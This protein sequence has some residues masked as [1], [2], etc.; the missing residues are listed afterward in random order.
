MSFEKLWNECGDVRGESC[1]FAGGD[2]AQLAFEPLE[3]MRVCDMAREEVYVPG[4]D[5]VVSGRSI[6][7]VEGGRIPWVDE[8]GL[9]P[10]AGTLSRYP[11]PDCQVI[12]NGVDGRDIRF[13][14]TTWYMD[15]QF[16]VDYVAKKV[17]LTVLSGLGN[18]FRE[19]VNAR[20]EA[21]KTFRLSYIGDSIT[22][23]CNASKLCDV[24]PYQPCYAELV[25]EELERATGCEMVFKNHAIGGTGCR[26]AMKIKDAWMGDKA[27]LLVIAYGMNDFSG[28]TAEDYVAVTDDI[29]NNAVAAHPDT[30]VLLV[31]SMAGNSDWKNTPAEPAEAFATALRAYAAQRP[32][33][34]FADV[35]A[36]WREYVSRKGYYSMT[37]NGVNHPNDFG[38]RVYASCL[39]EEILGGYL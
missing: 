1:M 11:S 18:G 30:L 37:G 23:G 26:N 2:V 17:D 5:Y 33:T 29:V 12:G 7:R 36:V 15:H 9:R 6:R 32:N 27:D 24:A 28:M 39:L 4:R 13:A 31:A 16:M 35:H 22:Y 19:A 14:R 34:G 25:A 21:G 10:A 20:L 8:E 38:Y 3:V